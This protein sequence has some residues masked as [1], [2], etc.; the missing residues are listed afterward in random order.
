MIKI[1]DS[2]R[3]QLR[4]LCSSRKDD[5]LLQWFLKGNPYCAAWVDN[6]K[7]PE[8]AIVLAADFCYLLGTVR[9]L[10]EIE[11]ILE[12]NARHKII[13]PCG[14]HW[15]TYLYEYLYKKVHRY[16]RYAIKHE[17]DSFDKSNLEQLI[18][19]IN[20]VYEIKQIDEEIYKEVLGIDWAADGCCFFRSYEDFKKNGLG[21]VVLKAGQL[22]CIASSYTAYQNTIGVTIGTLEEYR[23]QGLAAA[24]AATLILEC[25]ERDIYPEWEASNMNSVALAEKL[26]YHFDH[27]YDVYSIL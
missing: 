5:N 13:I 25:Q 1:N 9:H 6:V 18:K 24:C 27:A 2:E 17:P 10:D 26:G 11:Q 12:D 23:R 22:V 4:K 16:S 14:T 8:E 3:I 19:E 15:D 20:P 7:Q 21:Y